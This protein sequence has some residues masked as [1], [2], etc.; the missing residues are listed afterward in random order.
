VTAHMSQ[1][2]IYRPH[3]VREGPSAKAGDVQHYER[4]LACGTVAREEH[5]IRP[6]SGRCR[7]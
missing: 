2:C 6:A 4:L 3:R 7:R 5:Y 1:A